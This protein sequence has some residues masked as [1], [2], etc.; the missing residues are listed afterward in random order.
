MVIGHRGI[1]DGDGDG[2][3]G[4]E[5]SPSLLQQ[6]PPLNGMSG[7]GGGGMGAVEDNV[8][9][10][11]LLQL[12]RDIQQNHAEHSAQMYASQEV[13]SKMMATLAEQREL[14]VSLSQEVAFLRSD[15]SGTSKNGWR[16]GQTL[17]S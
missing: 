1:F 13:Q 11:V 3:K 15:I 12:A 2:E 6:L 8:S 16:S 14:I 9:T 7:G 17:T 4:G 10:R 5:L